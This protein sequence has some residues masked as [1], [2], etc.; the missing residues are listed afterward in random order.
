MAPVAPVPQ[1]M[2]TSR[3]PAFT[4]RA[5]TRRASSRSA[6]VR[7]PVA[8]ASVCVLAYIGST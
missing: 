2:T 8:D 1:K 4:D 5:M 3:S 6:V 7:R